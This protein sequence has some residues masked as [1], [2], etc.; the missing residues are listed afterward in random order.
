MTD[1][2]RAR[3]AQRWHAV[4]VPIAMASEFADTPQLGTLPAAVVASTESRVVVLEV[5]FAA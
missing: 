1:A 4:G 3:M 2:S 5:G